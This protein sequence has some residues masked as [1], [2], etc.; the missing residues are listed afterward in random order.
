M[1]CELIHIDPF[2]LWSIFVV[3][4]ASRMM[5]LIRSHR[6]PAA[7]SMLGELRLMQVH[8]APC[9]RDTN[10]IPIILFLLRNLISQW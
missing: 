3:E 5:K 7:V 2:K 9:R 1:L 10:Q 6:G 8:C 4:P